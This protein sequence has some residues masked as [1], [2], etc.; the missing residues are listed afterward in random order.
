MYISKLFIRSLIIGIFFFTT[1]PI[2]SSYA[3]LNINLDAD[4]YYSDGVELSKANYWKEAAIEF[5]KSIKIN[6]QHKLAHANLGVAL[7]KI[8]HHKEALLSFEKAIRLNYDHALIRYNKG[9]SFASLNLI[10]E[11]VSEFELSLEMDSRNVK[12]IYNLGQLYIKQNKPNAARKMAN[13]LYKRN[14]GLAKKLFDSIPFKYKVISVDNGGSLTGKISLIGDSPQPRFFPLIFSPNIEYC[15]R[16]S[17][18]KGHRILFDFTISDS[19]ELK[20]TIIKL[21][22]IKKGKPFSRK[23]QKLVMNRCHIPKYVIGVRNGESL[24]LENKDPIRHEVATYEFSKRGA[25]QK[26]N[27]PVDKNSSQFRDV[28][29]KHD[30][31]EFLLKCNLHPFLQTRGTMVDNPYYAISDKEGNFSIENIPPGTYKVIAWHPFIPNE[32]GMVSIKANQVSKID[33]AFKSKNIRRKLYNNDLIGYR[34]QPIYDSNKKF[35]GG[36]RNDDP[37]EILQEY[38]GVKN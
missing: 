29:V 26:S 12:A 30:T 36:L 27:R 8:G 33:F 32:I 37:I 4:R 6:P 23:I 19:Y 20:D 31:K 1:F 5:A 25:D 13:R 22:D 34:F 9:L 38:K 16:I 28:F 24:L 7:S 35:Y 17:D 10:E 14:N 21:I 18:G 11:A 3:N 15:T 2:A